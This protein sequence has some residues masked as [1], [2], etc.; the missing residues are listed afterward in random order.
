MFTRLK[1]CKYP[2]SKDRNA[3]NER[4]RKGRPNG[5]RAQ[6]NMKQ[7]RKVLFNHPCY[8]VFGARI[9]ASTR[10]ISS[11]RVSFPLGMRP[12][13]QIIITHSTK[14]FVDGLQ[15]AASAAARRP[16]MSWDLCGSDSFSQSM[17]SNPPPFGSFC[18]G[19]TSPPHI[20]QAATAVT[21]PAKPSKAF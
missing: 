17:P 10:A 18:W 3:S 14:S 13:C 7:K 15:R 9:F 19:K 21:I 8:A 16:P 4:P 11:S 6:L 12:L 1:G 20:P 5:G 2:W